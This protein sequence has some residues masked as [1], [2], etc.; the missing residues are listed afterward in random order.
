MRARTCSTWTGSRPES[1]RRIAVKRLSQYEPKLTGLRRM[2]RVLK[3]LVTEWEH[4]GA[5]LPCPII[6]TLNTRRQ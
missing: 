2:Q 1:I 6:E 3:H 5:E 4:T